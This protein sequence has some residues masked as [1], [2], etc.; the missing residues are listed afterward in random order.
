MKILYKLG[1]FLY[2]DLYETQDNVQIFSKS[3]QTKQGMLVKLTN[4][5]NCKILNCKLL[6]TPA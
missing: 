6:I 1:I 4:H 2:F 3:Q 5:F